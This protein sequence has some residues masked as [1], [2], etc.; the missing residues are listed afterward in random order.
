VVAVFDQVARRRG[1]VAVAEA[2]D[3]VCTICHVRMRPQVFNTV[4]RNDEIVQCEHCQRILF[5][6]PA[7][8]A[9]VVANSGNAGSSGN[10][11]N[12]NAA[13]SAAR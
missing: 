10:S 9:D 11:E 6:V 7:A 4:R 5:Y 3:G 1:G 13:S 8:T 2:R 12:N